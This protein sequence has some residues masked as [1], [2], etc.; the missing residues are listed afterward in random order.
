MKLNLYDRIINQ[1]QKMKIKKGKSS[2]N[3]KIKKSITIFIESENIF[4]DLTRK[5]STNRKYNC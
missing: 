3:S 2:S 5:T 4:K 1:R